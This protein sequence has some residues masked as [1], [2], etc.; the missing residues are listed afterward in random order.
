MGQQKAEQ[1]WMSKQ[2]LMHLVLYPRLGVFL[3]V[4][5]KNNTWMQEMQMQ[6]AWKEV[7]TMLKDQPKKLDTNAQNLQKRRRHQENQIQGEDPN[8]DFLQ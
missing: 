4:S 7:G 6:T 5:W 8:I 3:K 2:Q 1:P